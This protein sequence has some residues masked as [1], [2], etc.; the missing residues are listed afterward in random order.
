M[1]GRDS[2]ISTRDY[3]RLCDLIY[4][5]AGIALGAEKRTMLEVRIKR[6][7][8]SLNLTSYGEY[9]DAL[10]GQ[11]GMHE[12]IVALIDV[13]TTN[14]TDFFREATHFDFLVERALP[15][16]MGAN[17]G[18]PFTIWSAGCS[19]GEEPYTM[20]MV[21]SEFGLTHPGFRFRVL[22]TDISTTVLAK[23]EMGVYSTAQVEPVPLLLAA[24]GFER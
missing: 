13:V 5:E 3:T 2:S 9:C 8:K 23:A 7:L 11:K 24:A 22:A 1:S 19:T 20:A 17:G 4:Q 10:F 16:W 12:E 6:R 21:L 18:R 15:Q 14:K